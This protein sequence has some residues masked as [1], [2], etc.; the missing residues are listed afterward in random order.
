MVGIDRML[1]GTITHILNYKHKTETANSDMMDFGSESLS[2]VKYFLPQGCTSETF[3]NSATNKE[4]SVKKITGA[5]GGTFS[6][7]LLQLNYL[8]T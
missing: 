8:F 4:T 1:V 2:P 3:T 5:Y 6:F 7:K